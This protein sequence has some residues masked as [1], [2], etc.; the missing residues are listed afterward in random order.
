[1]ISQNL[2]KKE[3]QEA[4]VCTWDINAD[5]NNCTDRTN[6][7][8]KWDMKHLIR[9][10][11]IGLPFFIPVALGLIL[12][13]LWTGDWFGIIIYAMFWIF[14]FGFF[15]IRVLCRH[16]PYYSEE[17]KILHCLANHGL[18][19][20]WKYEPGPM[21]RWEKLGLLVGFVLF[22]GIPIITIIFATITLVDDGAE[23]FLVLI[24]GALSILSIGGA[25]VSG[26]SLTNKV[27]TRC[28][29]FSCPLNRVPKHLVD[30]Y[31]MK[32]PV[33]KHAWEKTGYRLS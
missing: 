7:D 25:F 12:T 8:C 23:L 11:T 3:V 26:H 10:Y 2:D 29:N 22:L 14:F 1:M 4:L 17:G 15:E 27:C 33:M 24:M 19:K 9:F 32:N 31:L 6:L 18:L 20:I 13:V 21:S 16:C 5:C 30:S 28:V